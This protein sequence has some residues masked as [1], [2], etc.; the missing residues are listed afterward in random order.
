MSYE[1]D[2]RR[3]VGSGVKVN[4]TTSLPP[5]PS[6]FQPPLPPIRHGNHNQHDG[7]PPSHYKN[8]VMRGDGHFKSPPMLYHPSRPEESEGE[9]RSQD[10]RYM[11]SHSP[12]HMHAI[13]SDKQMFH[14]K[15]PF[16]TSGKGGSFDPY[17]RQDDTRH[18]AEASRVTDRGGDISGSRGDNHSADEGHYPF[19]RDGLSPGRGYARSD[20]FQQQ[21]R[22][23]QTFPLAQHPGVNMYQNSH[24][25]KKKGHDPPVIDGPRLISHQSSDDSINGLVQKRPRNGN[26]MQTDPSTLMKS[27]T[28][29]SP[30]HSRSFS[31]D[32]GG[33]DIARFTQ[34]TRSTD[35][36]RIFQSWSSGNSNSGSHSPSDVQLCYN[37]WQ[38]PDPNGRPPPVRHGS[39]EENPTA[40][41]EEISNKERLNRSGTHFNGSNKHSPP[42]HPKISQKRQRPPSELAFTSS[43][44]KTL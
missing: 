28:P 30:L 21:P 35:N 19:S 13:P 44:R 38:A 24:L 14:K 5:A 10:G 43:P 15:S 25:K 4:N 9:N 23:Q 29:L 31:R 36:Y 22:P 39:W 26:V 6:V 3:D 40:N 11:Q 18:P 37:D 34:R 1:Y 17:Q 2:S 27:F 12:H 42:F 16:L 20:D 33:M 8:S 7:S 32:E 41:R